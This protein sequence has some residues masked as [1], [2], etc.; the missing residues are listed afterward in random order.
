MKNSVKNTFRFGAALGLLTVVWASRAHVNPYADYSDFLAEKEDLSLAID[1]PDVDLEWDLGDDP[2]DPSQEQDDRLNLEL[3]SNIQTDVE[4]DPETGTYQFN[5]T[6][7]GAFDYSNPS[8]MSME[9]YLQYT[10]E[11]ERADYW[12]EKEA[13]ESFTNSSKGFAPSLKVGGQGFDRIFG[14]NTVDIRPQGSAE[15]TFAVNT[16][17]TDNPQIPERQRRISTFDFNERIQLNVVGN[18]GTKMKLTTSY[19]TEATFD[20]ENQMKLEYTGQEDEIIQKIEAGN[21]SLPLTGSLITGSQSLFGIKTQLQFGRLTA[22]SIFSQQKGKRQELEVSGGAQVSTFNMKADNYEANKHYFLAH[23]FRDQY[24]VAMASLPNVNSGI[25]ITKIEVWVTNTNNTTQNTR[26]IIAFSDLGE[27]ERYDQTLGIIPNTSAST[28]GTLPTNNRNNIYQSISNNANIRD[29]FNANADLGTMTN[30]GPFSQTTDYERVENAR[31]LDPSEYSY[32]ALLG[33]ISLNQALN[34]DEVLAVAFEYTFQGETY[35]VGEISTDGVTGQ[36]ALI[37]KLLKATNFNPGL[38]IWDLM[39]KNVYSIGAYQVNPQDFILNV[40]YTN[41]TSGVDIQYIPVDPFQS[42]PLIQLV[43]LD[44]LNPQ[45]AATPDGIFDFVDG[46]STNGGTINAQNGRIFFPVIEPFGDHLERVLVDGGVDPNIIETI[47]FKELYDSTKIVAQQRPELNRFWLKGTY[48]S[49]SSSEI[50]LN[51]LNIPQGAVTV[52]AGGQQLTENVDYTV[53]YTLG[54]VKILNQGLLESGTPIKIS[55][56]SNSLFSIQT[57]TLLGTH[58]DYRVNKDFNMGAT[59]LNLTER[60][61]TQKVNIGDEPISN[62]MV[63]F[64]VDYRTESQFLTTLVDKIPFIDTKEKSSITATAEVAKLFPGNSR[65][66]GRDGVSYVDD[67]EGSQSAIDIRA[68]NNWV[69]ASTPSGQP[70]RFP[71]SEI[72]SANL[73]YGMN[74]AKMAWYV[75]DPL[76]FRNNSLTPAHIEGDPTVTSNVYMAEIFERD[77]FPNRQI[78]SGQP[79]NIPVLDFAFYPSERGPYNFDVGEYPTYAAGLNPDGSLVDPDSRWGGAMRQIQTNDFEAANIEFIQFWLM[80]PFHPDNGVDGA[81]YDPFHGNSN[82]SGGMLYFN[83]GNISEDILK[84]GY[85]SFENGLT[86]DGTF[87][88][89]TMETT[90][91]GRVPTTQAIVNAFDNDISSRIFQDVGLDGLGDDNERDFYADYLNEVQGIVS[92]GAYVQFEEDPSGDNYNYY[93]DDDYDNAQ[94]DIL[95]RYKLYNGVE[96]NS[97]TSEQA[98]TLNG[99]GYPTSATTLPNIEDINQDNNLSNNESYFEYEIEMTPQAINPGNI[100][101]NYITD[102]LI[103]PKN[104]P[105]GTTKEIAFYQFKIPIRNPDRVVNNIQDFRSIRFIR[106]YT[107]GFNDSIV[108]RFPRLEL[109]R[110]E[111]RKYD[112]S[113]QTEGEYMPDDPPATSFNIGAV[114][115]EENGN[116]TPVNYVLPPGI[117]QE[118]NAQSTNLTRLNEQSMA[119][120]VCNLQDGDARACFRTVDMDM[121]SYKKL[122]MFVHAEAQDENGDPLYDDDL[123]VFVRLGT[124]FNNNYYEYEMPLKVTPWGDNGRDEVWPALN[125]MIIEFQKLIEAKRLRDASGGSIAVPYSQAD[126]DNRITV[127]GNPNIAAVRTV[128]IGVRNPKQDAD[129]P[130]KPD[131]GLPK[132]AEIWVNE[133]RLTDFDQIG[134]WAATARVNAK[135]AD[136]GNVALAGNY[137]TPGWG[138]IEKRVSER[139]REE[140]I[141]LDASSTLNLGKFFPEKVGIKLP[142]FVGFS[143]SISNPQFDPLSPDVEIQ[144]LEFESPS[145]KRDYLRRSQTFIKRRSINFTNVRKERSKDAGKPHFYDIS[146]WS[147]TYSYNET[148]RRD[149][150]TEFNTQKQIRGGVAYAF[151]ASPKLVRPFNKSKFLKKSK[152]FRLIR[153]FNFYKGPKQLAFRTDINRNYTENQVRINTPGGFAIPT[154]TKQFN[155]LRVYDLKWDLTKSLKLDFNANNTALIGEPDGV[156]N[157]DFY[158]DEYEVFRDSVLSSIRNWGETTNYNQ[159]LNVNYTW[160]INKFPLT[161][162][163]TLTTRYSAGY[164][165]QRAPL[166]QDSLGHTIQNSRNINWNGQLN[167]TTL[168]NKIPYFKKVNQ[169]YGRGG[170]RRGASSSRTS[171]GGSGAESDTTKKKERSFNIL[172]QGARILMSL[173]NVS[174][175][176]SSTDGTLLPGYN[177]TTSLMGQNAA[178]TAP[179]LPFVFGQQDADLTGVLVRDFQALAAGNDWLVRNPYLNQQYA[180]THT[181]NFNARATLEPITGLRV[182]LSAN[183]QRSQNLNEFFRWGADPFGDSTYV[184]DSPVETGN[185]SMSVISWATAFS[186][187]DDENR[188]P[189]FERFLENRD[190]LSERLGEDNPNSTGEL[191]GGY[192]DGY[193]ATSQ[194]VVIPAFVAAYTGASFNNIGLNVLSSIPK[195]NWRINY[196]GLSKIKWVQKWAKTITLGH[197]YRS[198]FS[199]GNYTTNLQYRERNGGASARD[200]AGN[201]ISEYQITTVSITEQFSPLLN[202]DV[203]LKNSLLAK[204]EIKRDRNL[205]LSLTNQQ[206]TEIRG[207]ELVMGSG[208]RFEDVKLPFGIGAKKGLQSDLNLRADVSIRRNLTITRDM[209]TEPTTNQIVSGQTVISIKTAADYVIN[210]R[211]NV[212]FFFDRVVTR[213]LISTTFPT[214]NTNAGLALR[215]TLTS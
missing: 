167:M 183:R 164:D 208:Y 188:S 7:G 69:L 86:T 201:F 6:V 157:R 126:G 48:Q 198:S 114:N 22:T 136:F 174:F 35:Q 196:D 88:A 46:A 8:Y 170:K 1:S 130:W 158:P 3:P 67:F 121:R 146:N 169:K 148:F 107:Q 128:M 29:F 113:L 101:N 41:P 180:E 142:M 151:N 53:D 62:T 185:F 16:S 96:G 127:V 159:T 213:P 52:T 54:R 9:E 106:M 108:M 162:W 55:L 171:R 44:R 27:A 202:V 144:S 116:R 71:E 175:T 100:G 51:A 133:L 161:D 111:W 40:E 149:V 76:F 93:R 105:D 75:I 119:L 81:P 186:I 132:C 82:H 115:V 45:Q 74:R 23:Y 209:V 80:D 95:G 210:E 20:F 58:F 85:K 110:G 150:N 24:D 168:Y 187:D 131:D 112:F 14:G 70:T 117:N 13:A 89:S 155:W 25:N 104:M 38:P 42:R 5:Q 33:F 204:M 215:F 63:G 206:L 212:R 197:A 72:D 90:V 79:T 66:I 26:N 56:E 176:Y 189:V 60:P 195:P 50:S 64:N 191:S 10:E 102:V 98:A 57:K 134:G 2:L 193:G 87:D 94:L 124:D 140:I 28:G 34:N 39:M 194:D 160:P 123:T 166:S 68:V 21:V 154:Y 73:I 109:I 61:L 36:D 99:E 12:R 139:Q 178:F 165:W 31:R 192:F 32:N 37:L 43:N 59:V 141:Q 181:D 129:H 143:E 122:Q 153:D 205:A 4:Y 103:V 214:A 177:Q 17:R 65:A 97:A 11:Q 30:P 147:L 184:N 211:L 163:I 19:N 138:S 47:V 207:N 77:V 203:T 49:S 84:D 199:V 200:A 92:A 172:E 83:I 173:K 78:P 135:L 152:Y 91:W 18:I 118:I 179:G 120:E 182:E 137:S 156:V 15:L 145:D 190:I 125:N